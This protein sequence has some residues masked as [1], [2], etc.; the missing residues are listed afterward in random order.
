MK[1]RLRPSI[2][3][4]ASPLQDREVDKCGVVKDLREAAD[5]L[6]GTEESRGARDPVAFLSYADKLLGKF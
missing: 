4:G 1:A 5:S 3:P 2:S 6:P